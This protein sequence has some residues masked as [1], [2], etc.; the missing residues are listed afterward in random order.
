MLR[1]KYCWKDSK[2]MLPLPLFKA[3]DMNPANYVLITGSSTGLGKAFAVEC[4]RRGKN[5]LLV[6]LPGEGLEELADQINRQYR[7]ET[8]FFEVDLTEEDAVHRLVAWA[9]ER[10]RID[11]LINNAGFGGSMKLDKTPLEYLDKMIKLNVR[12]TSLLSYLL[13][14]ELKSHPQAYILNVSSTIAFNPVAY[15]TFYPGSKAYVYFLSR[16]LNFELKGSG[17]HVS[18]L[19]AGPMKTNAFVTDSIEKQGW[20]AKFITLEPE[21]M[22]KAAID[23]LL[24]N[25]HVIIP[26]WANKLSVFLS[27]LVPDAIRLPAV[28][29][30][31]LDEI[32]KKERSV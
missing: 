21:A 14:P 30:S 27:R 15:K 31:I 22:A 26:G 23:G 4:A 6:S 3:S 5:I 2:K 24:R 9:L 18:V 20:K 11:M 25:Q 19:L 28:S 17:T 32:E 7:V 8:A 12:A 29:R 1:A 13:I 10:F 16:G